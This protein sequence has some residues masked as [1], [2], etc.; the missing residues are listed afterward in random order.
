M[1]NAWRATAY[2][3]LFYFIFGL[4]L[5][6][7]PVW[8][9]TARGLDGPQISFVLFGA[10]LARVIVG[11]VI[12]GWA[13]AR[14]A[15][16]ASVLMAAGAGFGYFV[17][18]LTFD[19]I[20]LAIVGFFLMSIVH[21]IIPLGESSL[22]LVAGE[23]R[24]SF[25]QGRALASLSFVFGVFSGG[26]LIQYVGVSSLVPVITC[27]FVGLMLIGWLVP[28]IPLGESGTEAGLWSRMARGIRLYRRP[29]LYLLLISA[30]CIQA[31]HAFYYGFST[32]IWEKQGFSGT[33]ISFLWVT[34]VLLEIAFLA[35]A[36]KFPAW[37]TPQRLVLIGAIGAVLRWVSYGFA[38][39]LLSA[40]ILQNLHA[41]TFAATFIG[42]VRMVH[43][44]VAKQDQTL[45]L[46]LL[47]AIAGA[48]TGAAGVLSGYLYEGIGVRGYWAMA[49]LAAIGGLFACLM[50]LRIS[51]RLER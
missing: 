12:S 14:T 15:K 51:T 39:D 7:L 18:N 32:V 42:G 36:S 11:P 5:P 45:A 40:F 17:L 13:D 35:F 44:E 29:T 6:Y 19:P 48:M 41:L 20:F 50:M 10:L 46:S 34:G 25:G 8:L 31:A 38:P 28:S 24:P 33:E 49:A 26:F 43:S 37:V 16:I 4:Q 22:L 21:A 30:S 47:A 1:S 27:L 9:E 23:S 3:S 2:L